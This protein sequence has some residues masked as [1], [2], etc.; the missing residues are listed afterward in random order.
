MNP[1]ADFSP[2]Q[3]PADEEPMEGFMTT[4]EIIEP[5]SDVLL[6]EDLEFLKEIDSFQAINHL[7]GVLPERGIEDVDAFLVE[8]GLLDSNGIKP[9]EP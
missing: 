1:E 2:E 4:E 9:N 3:P 7:Y 8:R 5:L 6:E